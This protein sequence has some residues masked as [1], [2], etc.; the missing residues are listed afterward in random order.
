M[1]TSLIVSL[2]IAL[3]VIIVLFK[4]A[5]IVPQQSAFVVEQLGKFNRKLD[6]GFHFLIPFELVQHWH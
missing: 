6:A 2:A 4:A 3:L 1:E 5:V